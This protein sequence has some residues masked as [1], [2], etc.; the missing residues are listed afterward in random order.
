MF[1]TKLI[2]FSICFL[3]IF[4][5]CAT[6]DISTLRNPL[7]GSITFSKLLVSA[8]FQDLETRR[9]AESSF[10]NKFNELGIEAVMAIDLIPP[11]KVYTEEE[12]NKII[13]TNHIDG[14]LIATLTDYYT[15]QAYVPESSKTTGSATVYGNRI[16][17]NSTTRKSGG[18]YIN[19]P[20]V[21]FEVNIYTTTT[22]DIVWKATSFTRGNAFANQQTLLSSLADEVVYA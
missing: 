13:N 15:D 9:I 6:T 17:G 21:R 7:Y 22:G 1:R 16:Y 19:K 10:V 18:Y 12:I 3:A 4:L 8:P 11:I 2:I 14:V 20:R 5:G